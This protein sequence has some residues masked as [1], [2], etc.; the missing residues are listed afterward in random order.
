MLIVKLGS[1]II[2]WDKHWERENL[3][4]SSWDGEDLNLAKLLEMECR[5]YQLIFGEA[6]GRS[7]LNLFER[8]V[9]IPKLG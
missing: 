3:E 8:K 5:H 7:P 1:G 6:D 2:F 9:W 4:R